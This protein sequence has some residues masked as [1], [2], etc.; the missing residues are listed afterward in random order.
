MASVDARTLHWI[1]TF[2]VDDLK[3]CLRQLNQPIS[4]RKAE[5]QQRLGSIIRAGMPQPNYTP[6]LASKTRAQHASA[7]SVEVGRVHRCTIS[8]QATS[9]L[10]CG[11]VTRGYTGAVPYMQP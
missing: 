11:Q 2:K 8:T 10:K 1:Q 4:G 3:S 5:L 6:D 9:S 7:W